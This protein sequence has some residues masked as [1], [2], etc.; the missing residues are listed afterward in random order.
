MSRMC[1]FG[2]V[3]ASIILA[4][5][6]TPA[7]AQTV[8]VIEYYNASQDHYFISALPADINALDSGQLKGWVRTGRS[9][10]AYAQ[11]AAG[12]SPV[13]RFYIPPANGDSHFYSAS[14]VECAQV[15]AKFPFFGYESPNVMYI[16]LPDAASGA[17]PTGDVPVYRVWDNRADSN[18][19]YTTDRAVRTQMVAKGWLAEGYG[20]DQVI[21]CAPATPIP[22]T[23]FAMSAVGRDYPAGDHRHARTPGIR[24][25][26]DR[27]VARELRLPAV[28]Q[29]HGQRAA[30]RAGRLRPPTSPTWR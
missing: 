2:T 27:E 7:R 11:A 28:R 23:F 29:L 26:A 18:H 22:S 8:A 1:A 21:M 9:F 3:A 17:C 10:A 24:L 13:C 16:D 12:A 25:G 19:R 15:Q 20:P 4:L 5:L 14:P 6:A 30:E